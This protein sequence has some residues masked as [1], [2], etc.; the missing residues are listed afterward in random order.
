M[1]DEKTTSAAG[2]AAPPPDKELR[3]LEPL[4]GTW[5]AEDHTQD[6]VLGPVHADGTIHVEWWLCDERGE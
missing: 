4:L 3:R 2:V 1:T 6:S 5:K